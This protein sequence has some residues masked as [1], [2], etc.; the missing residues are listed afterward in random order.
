[1][2]LQVV[3]FRAWWQA[4]LVVFKGAMDKF[5]TDFWLDLTNSVHSLHYNTQKY[6]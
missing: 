3:C 2:R 1:M 6:E 5:S 4:R